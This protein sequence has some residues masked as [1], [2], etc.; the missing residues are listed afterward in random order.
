MCVFCL[1][2]GEKTVSE[3]SVEKAAVVFRGHLILFGAGKR[4]SIFV[5]VFRSLRSCC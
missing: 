5:C 2:G 3:R 1:F 4:L